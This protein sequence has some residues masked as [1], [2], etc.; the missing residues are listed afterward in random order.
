MQ[1]LRIAGANVVRAMVACAILA[2]AAC[3]GGYQG[4]PRAAGVRVDLTGVDVD[5]HSGAHYLVLED[6]AGRRSLQIEIDDAGAHAIMLA[7]QG[8]KPVRPLSADLLRSVIRQTG[9]QVDRVEIADLRGEI[10]YA[11]IDLDRGRYSI[12]SRP[13]DAIALALGAGAPIY[14]AARLM[15]TD[16]PPAAA[17]NPPAALATADGVTVQ[18][19][20]ADLA[21]AF[22]VGAHSGV[23]VADCDAGDA[24]AGLQRGDIVTSVAGHAVAMPD[25]F[26][27][28][29]QAVS[30]VTIALRILRDGRTVVIALPVERPAHAAN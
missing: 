14:V 29:A 8:V 24:R 22:G 7:M 30:A 23:V 5:R 21:T 11:R 16:Q 19:L 6:L 25:D 9:N 15:Q 2:I 26:A 10:Y 18:E 27:R 17:A 12:D 4:A 3:N 20:T 13:S 28:A 1:R